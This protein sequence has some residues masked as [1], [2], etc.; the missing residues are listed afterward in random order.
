MGGQTLNEYVIRLKL[1]ADSE[2]HARRKFPRPLPETT[3]QEA[4]ELMILLLR[5]AF[6]TVGEEQGSPKETGKA[7][8][9]IQFDAALLRLIDADAS[10]L[11]LNRT[12]WL[13]AAAN[14][15]LESTK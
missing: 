14:N 3:E 2:R 10:R 12:A 4:K 15:M 1:T 8:A 5:K 11:G 6:E 9:R 13:H 7:M